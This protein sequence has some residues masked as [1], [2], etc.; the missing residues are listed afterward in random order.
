[1]G[2]EVSAMKYLLNIA[3]K[4]TNYAGWQRQKNANTIQEEVE[5]ALYRLYK[6]PVIIMGASRTD[7]G[8]HALGQKCTFSVCSDYITADK[9][10]Y[11]INSKLPEDIAVTYAK[12][13]DRDFHP[14]F[15]AKSKTYIYK[16]YNGEFRNPLLADTSWHIYHKIN[17]AHMKH[18][19]KLFTGCHDFSAFCA[20]G[21]SAKSFVRQINF[22]NIYEEEKGIICFEV[23]GNG[24][25]YNMVRI[26][27]GTLAYVG[28]GKIPAD[29]I[30]KIIESKNR[31]KAGIT[32]PPEG[33]CLKEVY[34]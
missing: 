27:A 3:Y 34:Y 30:V 14:I 1:M 22:A 6:E 10:P 7:T 25:L 16:I 24:F 33:L 28:M 11:A 31:D 12:A 2:Y 8:V 20:A 4:G 15:D 21:G 19:A 9:L 18:A 29:D 32:A 5:K 23:N 13:V 17:I 26:M